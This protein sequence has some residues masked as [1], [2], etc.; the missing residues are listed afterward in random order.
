MLYEIAKGA[1]LLSLFIW[2][3]GMI[4]V[5]VA[6][7]APQREFLQAIKVYD[8]SVTTPAMI[9][10]L[11]FGVLLGVLG[12]WFSSGWLGLKI[13]LVLVLTG[14]HGVLVGRL[15]RT[16]TNNGVVPGNSLDMLILVGPLVL[17]LI[18][19]LVVMKP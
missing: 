12:G 8:R 15:R 2:I 3:G 5:L 4:A 17:L 9:A 19:L 11:I 6:L 1:H 7:R 14:L 13:I 10:A 18:I 16:I